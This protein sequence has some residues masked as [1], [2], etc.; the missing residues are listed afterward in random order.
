MNEQLIP[1][2][3]IAD[4]PYQHREVYEG[5]EELGRTIAAVGLQ[6]A[7]KARLNG[8]G[9]QLKFGHR[10]KRAFDWLLKNYIKEGLPDRYGGYTVMPLDIEELTDRELFD[11]MVIE[12]TQRAD[13]KP[14]EV[15]QL[16]KQYQET[17]P[18][19][20]S[21]EIGLVF[22][23]NDATVRGMV[24][25]LDLPK[26]V[27]AKLDDGT[28]SQGTA[29]LFH[30]MQKIASEDK[31]VE[32]LKRIEKKKGEILPEKV[33]EQ[34]ID[35]L[36]D[37]VDMWD[38]RS[39]D[40]KPRAGYHGWPLEMKNFPKQFLPAM[41]EQMVARYEQQI[42]HLVD[43]PACMSCPFYTKVS[44]SHYCGLK[45]C[46]ERKTVA[47]LASQVEQTSKSTKIPIYVES[48]GRFVLLENSI[49]A[50][51]LFNERHEGLRLLSKSLV[52]RYNYQYFKGVDDDV[53]FVVATGDAIS[54]L[55]T[56]GGTQKGGKMTE[57]EK[58]DRRAMKIY[59]VRRIE[60]F[61]EF[62]GLAKSLF[63]NIPVDVLNT[64]CRWES[65]MI[66]DRI[67]EEHSKGNSKPEQK[68]DYQ[69]RALV[70]RLIM[71]S[72]SHNQR[73]AL[74]AILTDMQK[75]TGVK[76]SK[77]LLKQATQWDAEINAAASV[78]T[79]TTKVQSR[80][81]TESL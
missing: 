33:I 51:K 47:W 41:N 52:R 44:G 68:A 19:A 2:K 77:A 75:R 80:Q 70:W 15:A 11:A 27:Q 24:R 57:K 39:G 14:T 69:R 42:A 65:I 28:I 29:R 43:P 53:C 1:L 66:D 8:K 64:I 55:D 48:D 9:Y 31:I 20:T 45:I 4:N 73:K 35:H 81:R 74:S 17:F 5:I 37:A 71:H 62:T 36:P 30:S 63:D 12:N 25:L 22:N 7:P 34:A 58:A 10:R 50:D 13:L 38:E 16:L 79:A 76:P 46:Y 23:M 18:D 32:T 6:Q 72:G 40:G 54:K 78:S 61:W 67:P 56:N 59:R 26:P 49:K 21:K 3:Q 60:L